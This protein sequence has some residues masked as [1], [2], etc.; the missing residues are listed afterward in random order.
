MAVELHLQMTVADLI[1]AC[2]GAGTAL[3]R[4]GMACVGC[5]MARFETVSE[6][7]AA[8]GVDPAELLRLLTDVPRPRPATLRRRKDI[9][10]HPSHHP[11]KRRPSS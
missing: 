7:G 4:R 8:Y 10:D 2:P 1:A 5:P 3:A 9:L 11:P 6:A